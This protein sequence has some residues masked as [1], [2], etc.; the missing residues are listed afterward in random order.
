MLGDCLGWCH[1]IASQVSSERLS[2]RL[3]WEITVWVGSGLMLSL[4]SMCTAVPVS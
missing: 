1:G 2:L 3:N 4:A